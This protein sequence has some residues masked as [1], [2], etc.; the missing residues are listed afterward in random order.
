MLVPWQE[1]APDSLYNLVQ[2]I[3]LREGTDYGEVE[4]S[5]AEKTEQLLAAI[6]AG[7]AF[8]LYSELDESFDVVSK[9]EF[10]DKQT[11][12]GQ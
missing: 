5:V 1:I 8:I 2:S 6:K 10:L 9:Q 7:S 11:S 3:V 12:Q 4:F